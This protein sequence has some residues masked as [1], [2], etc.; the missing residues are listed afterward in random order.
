MKMAG[1]RVAL[2]PLRTLRT[3]YYVRQCLWRHGCC[4]VML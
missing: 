3:Y 1:C 4:D 2:Y